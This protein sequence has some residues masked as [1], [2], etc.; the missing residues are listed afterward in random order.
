MY[1]I[2]STSRQFLHSAHRLASTILSTPCNVRP[3]K[4][5]PSSTLNYTILELERDGRQMWAAAA[6][7]RTVSHIT[8]PNDVTHTDLPT[9]TPLNVSHKTLTMCTSHADMGA[10][11]VPTHDFHMCGFTRSTV[12]SHITMSLPCSVTV[13]AMLRSTGKHQLT[14]L[15]L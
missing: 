2:L 15:P 12:P 5:I 14:Q 9:L 3:S 11:I 10:S 6:N 7:G 8:L 1:S 4:H 13:N